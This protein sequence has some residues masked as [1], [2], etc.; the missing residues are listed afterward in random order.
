MIQP[1]RILQIVLSLEVGGLEKVV[2]DLVNHATEGFEFVICCLDTQGVLVSKILRPNT[3]VV[4]L[5]RRSGLDFKLP[6]RIASVARQE[7][8][9]LIH[10]HNAAAHLYGSIGGK[11]SRLPVLH[12]EH[13]KQSDAT[14][15]SYRANRI[16]ARFT[17]FH[18][19]VSEKIRH[20][21]ISLEKVP[22]DE[23][24]LIPNGID[25]ERY[26]RSVDINLFRKELHLRPESLVI[27]T[28]GRLAPVK[29]YPLL[30]RA[31]ARVTKNHSD[32][33]LVLV[34]D[35]PERVPLMAL[36]HTVGLSDRIHFLGFR[37][38][39]PDILKAFNVFVLCSTSEGCSI[40]LQEAMAAG[41]P[42]VA[43][44]VGGNSDL[45][46]NGIHGLLVPSENEE[47]L[48]A[49]LTQLS[50]DKNLAQALA[51]NASNKAGHE[52]GIGRMVQRYE[53][54]WRQLAKTTL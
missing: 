32:A 33:H 29:N 46:Q 34:G 13:G 20:E 27:G 2:L 24:R 19:A 48:I 1:I 7:S 30:L 49:A 25:S 17:N 50:S 47:A 40:A 51:R 26:N 21:T 41:C 43:T 8:I 38:D 16:A 12:T 3:K 53:E 23:V 28:I 11:L 31:F 4:V 22:E 18:V 45:I 6:F 42:I 10:T 37:N 39:I 35:G 14:S 36:A 52:Y 5:G 54:L 9:Q 15:R 44:A